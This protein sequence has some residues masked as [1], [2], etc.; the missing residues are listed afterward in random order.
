MLQLVQGAE[1]QAVIGACWYVHVTPLLR[2][3][4]WL[5][6]GF[7]VQLKLLVIIYIALHG[8]GLCYFQDHLSLDISD[9][10]TSTHKVD[11]LQVLCLKQ[12]HLMGPRRHASSVAE[13]VLWNKL[14]LRCGW[15]WS[16][17]FH[18]VVKTLL[19]SHVLDQDGRLTSSVVK[20]F[21]MPSLGYVLI[22]FSYIGF[23]FYLFFYLFLLMYST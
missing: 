6:I 4:H 3:L 11:M 14:P 7:W 5:L 13:P 2:E 15:L 23:A 19:F 20:V 16:L 21:A 10:P 1:V 22:M 17:S 9:S 12:W 18:R 8:T